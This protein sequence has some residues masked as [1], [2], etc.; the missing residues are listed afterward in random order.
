MLVVAFDVN[1]FISTTEVAAP[2]KHASAINVYI[3]ALNKTVSPP[4][5]SLTFALLFC[6]CPSAR[7][8]IVSIIPTIGGASP[9]GTTANWLARIFAIFIVDALNTTGRFDLL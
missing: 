4:V 6:S 3:V 5:L 1:S 7:T 9:R 2:N 8:I